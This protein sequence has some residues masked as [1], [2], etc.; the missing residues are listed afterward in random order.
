[1]NI[2]ILI[3]AYCPNEKLVQLIEKLKEKR[4]T[5][6]LVVDDG[7][8]EAY[9]T[10]FKTL[11]EQG[12]SMVSHSENY[13]KGRAIK[14]GMK[15]LMERNPELEF[16]IT[17]DCDG[18]HLAEDIWNLSKGILVGRNSL[19]LGIRDFNDNRVPIKSRYGNKISA[20]Y[21]KKV[22]GVFCPD[23]QTGL[24]AIP[25][26]LFQDALETEGERYEYEM[27]FLIQ[28]AKKGTPIEYLPIATVYEEKNRGSHFHAV[29]DSYQVL[30]TPLRYL[31]S[32]ILCAIVDLAL[33]TIVCH[34]QGKIAGEQ[35]LAATI[36]ARIAS[37][38]LN[39]IL[40]RTWSFSS[41][42]MAR[43][44]VM[45]YAALFC[46]QMFLSSFFVTR[47]VWMPVSKT[48]VKAVVDSIL[49]C[50]SYIVQKNWVFQAKKMSVSKS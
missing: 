19:W 26:C 7:S 6:I 13:G 39:F 12:V 45:K 27:N 10:I 5:A 8:G 34:I 16:I 4:F 37:G 31:C 32:S 47:L 41:H 35:I 24:R 36:I 23:T 20:F 9:Q 50:V 3:P 2:G 40:N 1:M 17:A 14:T 28:T 11:E 33:F 49:F 25:A 48:V 46:T 15:A 43:A 18:Q 38:I 42:S 22:T 29:R 30:K 21:F 44:Q